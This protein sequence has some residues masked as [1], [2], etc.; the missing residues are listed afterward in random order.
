M[1]FYRYGSALRPVA[2]KIITAVSHDERI[3]GAAPLQPLRHPS[4][5]IVRAA[6]RK[7][8]AIAPLTGRHDFTLALLIGTALDAS[9]PAFAR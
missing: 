3:G 6:D 8:I 4:W 2:S 5:L 1:L 9:P 7:S